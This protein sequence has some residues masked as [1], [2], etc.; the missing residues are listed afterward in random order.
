MIFIGKLLVLLVIV[1]L[2]L[3]LPSFLYGMFGSG[4]ETPDGLRL[5][6]TLSAILALLGGIVY[7]AVDAAN[8][9]NRAR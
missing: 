6:G 1:L 5:L 4:D 2:I 3:A 7:L 9:H 8:R